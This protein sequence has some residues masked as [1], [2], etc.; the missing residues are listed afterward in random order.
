MEPSDQHKAP[1]NKVQCFISDLRI[2]AVRQVHSISI[3]AFYIWSHKLEV[4]QQLNTCKSP[5]H[6]SFRTCTNL[7]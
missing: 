4:M 3:F 5:M 1:L 7:P 6:P 2:V